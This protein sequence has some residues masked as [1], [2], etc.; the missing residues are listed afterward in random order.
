MVDILNHATLASGY[1]SEE[2]G[3]EVERKE[4]SKERKLRLEKEKKARKEKEKQQKEKEKLEKEKE[5]QE[6]EKRQEENK[7]T[8]EEEE[9]IE[10]SGMEVL[11]GING[12]LW[13]EDEVTKNFT[14]LHHLHP[15]AE[16][17]SLQWQ[18]EHLNRL[19]KFIVA[20]V[21][22][23]AI[24]QILESIL[25]ALSATAA[26]V[27]AALAIPLYLITASVLIDNPWTLVSNHAKRAGK[28]LAKVLIERSCGKRPVS[29]LGWSHGSRVIFSALEYLN[30]ISNDDYRGI[31]QNV[32]LIGSP[33]TSKS[34]R[35]AAVR[36][37]IAGRMVNCY[38]TADWLLP[39]IHRAATGR[40][41]TV[42]GVTV[43]SF[44]FFFL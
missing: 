39:I 23:E 18:T 28:L 19:G 17:Y 34:K 9:L 26:S 43:S 41:K 30:K 16:I 4:S 37:L 5:K 36:P 25:V 20:F 38:S 13:K 40:S 14:K 3:L 33:V 7:L 2:N 42:A 44:F 11:I 15:G 10:S 29:L 6:Q 12:W 22:D 27:L 8:K 1:I 35:W 24:G 21:T 31:I 32:Y